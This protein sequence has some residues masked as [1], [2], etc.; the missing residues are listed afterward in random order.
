[1]FDVLGILETTI[2]QGL[3]YSMLTLGLM[4]SF[5]IVRFPDLTADGSFL[6]G[7]AIAA[8]F[9]VFHEA[10]VWGILAAGIGGAL[11]GA[12]TASASEFLKVPRILSGILVMTGLYSASLYVMR[13]SNIPLGSGKNVLS[14]LPT[15][16]GPVAATIGFFLALITLIYLVCWWL[17]RSEWGLALRAVG[18][19]PDVVVAMA[20]NPKVHVIAGLIWSNGLI[21]LCGAFCAHNNGF[22]DISSGMGVLVL[23][24]TALSLGDALPLPMR[25]PANM[26]I[27]ALVGT[28]IT[29]F[30]DNVALQVIRSTD[31]LK[32][33]RALLLLA[34]L[35]WRAR[36]R[37][38]VL[39]EMFP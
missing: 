37:R 33:F 31:Y 14:K 39:Q 32:A 17:L 9:A 19:A 28:L 7:T 18:S 6:I 1:M 24:L 29:Q 26:L 25:S 20:R 22:A 23:G 11:A 21:G 3:L 16:G 5:K 15:L 2:Q 35:A 36:R 27:A 34:A 12:V 38:G 13:G 4:I 10:P 8:A 30:L